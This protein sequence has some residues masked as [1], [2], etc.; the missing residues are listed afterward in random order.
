MVTFTMYASFS[1][2]YILVL[3]YSIFLCS[4]GGSGQARRTL[5]FPAHFFP[6]YLSSQ[7]FSAPFSRCSVIT[8]FSRSVP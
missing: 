7:K 4:S 6:P 2:S 3:L 5:A 1:L 8:G